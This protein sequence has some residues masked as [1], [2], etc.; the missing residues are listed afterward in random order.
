LPLIRPAIPRSTPAPHRNITAQ[1]HFLARRPTQT[2]LPDA[3]RHS[4]ILMRR[5]ATESTADRYGDIP[6]DASLKERLK[7]LMKKY[8]WYAVGVYLLVGAVDFTLSF[9]AINLLGADKVQAA[10][11]A[12]KR[13]VMEL[14]GWSKEIEEGSEK[15]EEAA[16]DKDKG[17]REGL[18][19]MLVLA[20]TIHKTVFMPVRIGVTATATP[21]LVKYLRTRGWVG[22]EGA[23]QAGR[24][25]KQKAQE[26]RTKARLNK[27]EITK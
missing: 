5:L 27:Q 19:A 11:Q 2:A 21:G 9:V 22:Q 1:I 8:G 4:K 23:R 14:V 6:K 16:Q 12:A 13:K 26:M 10:A 3:F 18:Y 17:G 15:I 20:Y 24:E 25:I 7:H